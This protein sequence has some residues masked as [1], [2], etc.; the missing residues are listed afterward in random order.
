MRGL[1]SIL[2]APPPFLSVPASLSFPLPL[3]LSL[4]LISGK[5][6]G[7]EQ[8]EN[9]KEEKEEEE[10]EEEGRWGNAR[11]DCR[12][13]DVAVSRHGAREGTRKEEKMEEPEG[14]MLVAMTRK[15]ARDGSRAKSAEALGRTP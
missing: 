3:S 2:T 11:G 14:A 6:K 15:P 9:E 4:S 7:K 10:E 8:G 13:D 1:T 5:G 12:G